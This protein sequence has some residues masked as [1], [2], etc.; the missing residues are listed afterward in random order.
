[1]PEM[2]HTTSMGSCDKTVMIPSAFVVACPFG[3]AGAKTP[4]L[5]TTIGVEEFLGLPRSSTFKGFPPF[6]AD[7][8]MVAKRAT[9]SRFS[10]W[11]T[12]LKW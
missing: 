1:M 10:E 6:L 8:S 3:V 7:S 12:S 11:Y 2:Q 9:C 5:R 4:L